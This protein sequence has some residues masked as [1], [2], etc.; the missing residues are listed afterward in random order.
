MSGSPPAR[1]VALWHLRSST[2][3]GSTNSRLMR[4]PP[5]RF[6]AAVSVQSDCLPP[7]GPIQPSP[8]RVSCDTHSNAPPAS[9][10]LRANRAGTG[11]PAFAQA[12]AS[13]TIFDRS[14]WWN[15]GQ[16][17]PP[18]RFSTAHLHGPHQPIPS[19]GS[20][21]RRPAAS[22]RHHRNALTI[23]PHGC[24]WQSLRLRVFP[25]CKVSANCR[26]IEPCPCVPLSLR[27]LRAKNPAS[28]GSCTVLSVP[29]PLP[30]ANA[31]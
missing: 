15:E 28:T 30:S 4:V 5:S 2:S 10:R 19:C 17:L 1:P 7:K 12:A 6:A 13:K 21:N 24:H 27:W 16:Q 23:L 18:R 20:I 29:K 26:V 25:S 8:N 22:P 11:A 9:A 14:L 3:G 31:P